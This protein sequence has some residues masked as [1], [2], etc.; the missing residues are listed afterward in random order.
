ME[1]RLFGKHKS[2][3]SD[4][5][6]LSGKRIQWKK[7]NTEEVNKF[8]KINCHLIHK[9]GIPQAWVFASGKK[10]HQAKLYDWICEENGSYFV[11]KR[12]KM[13][14]KNLWRKLW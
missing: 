4:K 12:W 8:L 13:W 2:S 14:F 11:V 6:S 1:R 3:V 7:E 5:N 9:E 10:V